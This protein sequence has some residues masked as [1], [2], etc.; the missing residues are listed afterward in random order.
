MHGMNGSFHV[1]VNMGKVDGFFACSQRNVLEMFLQLKITL[2]SFKFTYG[3]IFF[4]ELDSVEPLL[5]GK[6]SALH[7]NSSVLATPVES[8]R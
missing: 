1:C 3:K 7:I 8:S 5:G 2:E 4:W 6:A